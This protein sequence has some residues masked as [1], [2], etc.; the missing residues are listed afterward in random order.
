MMYQI[1]TENVNQDKVREILEDSVLGYCMFGGVG[2]Y[3][4]KPEKSLMI[5]L[6]NVTRECCQNICKAI[7][8]V[9]K[10]EC[11]LLVELSAGICFA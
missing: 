10:Q 8:L 4:G 5:V 7:N 1:Y 2:A 11:C 9:N 6:V 3:N